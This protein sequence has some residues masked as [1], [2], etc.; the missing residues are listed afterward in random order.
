VR[1]VV[2]GTPGGSVDTVVRALAQ[3]LTEQTGGSFVVDD[4]SARRGS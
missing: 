4:L 3:K 2:P 1:F